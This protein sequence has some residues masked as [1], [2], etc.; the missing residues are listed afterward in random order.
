[1]TDNILSLNVGQTST[2]SPVTY[3]ADGV[4]PS[5]ATYSAVSY[6]FSDPSATVVVN[7]DGV[8]AL[9]TGVAASSGPIS[10]AVSFTATDTDGAVSQWTQAFTIQTNGTQPPPPPSQLSQSAAVQ[11]S[12][13]A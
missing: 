2:A 4:T 12:T 6:A 3:L 9:V 10:G 1:M 8:T 13:P 7:S 11:F 5:G